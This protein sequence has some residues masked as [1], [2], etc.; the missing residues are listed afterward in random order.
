MSTRVSVETVLAEAQPIPGRKWKFHPAVPL[1]I[2]TRHDVAQRASPLAVLRKK[3]KF[4]PNKAGLPRLVPNGTR[5][6][7]VTGATRSEWA[8]ENGE[9]TT[10]AEVWPENMPVKGQAEFFLDE[11][12]HVEPN[13]RVKQQLGE[14]AEK[15]IAIAV[16]E[17][18]AQLPGTQIIGA[19]RT[20]YGKKNGAALLDRTVKELKRMWPRQIAGISAPV[21]AG[22]ALLISSDT[23]PA[24]KWRKIGPQ[25][26]LHRARTRQ[27][28][29]GGKGALSVHVAALLK[30]AR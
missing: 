2:V 18:R 13:I 8:K 30:G 28:A 7:A 1:E 23:R 14:V 5:F 6:Y 9:R 19:F 15:A 20:I 12:Q 3:G 25:M 21:V 24:D 26:L 27:M 16:R 10:P 11:L 22:T 29:H 4:D 17:A